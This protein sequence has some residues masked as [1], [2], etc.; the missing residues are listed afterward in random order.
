MMGGRRI[1]DAIMRSV[2]KISI[3]NEEYRNG[4]GSVISGL[5]GSPGLGEPR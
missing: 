5:R 3:G 2:S 1:F 4:E